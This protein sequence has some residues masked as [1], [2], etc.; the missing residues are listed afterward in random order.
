LVG[1]RTAPLD[2]PRAATLI[3]RLSAIAGVTHVVGLRVPP[4]GSV[5]AGTRDENSLPLVSR[6]ADLLATRLATCQDPA[7]IVVIDANGVGKGA[8]GVAALPTV[9]PVPAA[10]LDVAPLA[11][12]VVATDGRSAAIE[13]ART[14]MESASGVPWSDTAV[15]ALNLGANSRRQ[16]VTLMRISN[17]ALV[18]TLL[19]AGFSLAVSV[20]G[21]LV[22]RKRPFALLRLAGM[23]PGELQRVLLVET[24][25]PL[26]TVAVSSAALGLVM[27][28]YVLRV[29]QVEWMPP[30]PLYWGALGGGLLLAL[31][32]TSAATMPLVNRLTSLQT[33]RFE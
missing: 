21:G 1:P 20:A 28:A 27:A 2:P 12:V 33:A 4:A 24:A 11:A 18:L 15:T 26:L 3:G 32:V 6:C 7:A 25:A 31:A 23:R 13:Q 17:G 22:E 19:I 5:P 10:S 29:V 30:E 8:F 16:A 14:E 9:R